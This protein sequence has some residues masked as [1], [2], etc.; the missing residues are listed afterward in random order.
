MQSAIWLLVVTFLF[1]HGDLDD[2]IR[3]VTQQINLTPD[4]IELY[5]MRGELYVAH[6]EYANAISD[7][8]HCLRHHVTNS[9]I[10]LGLS[11]SYLHSNQSD[12]ALVIIDKVLTLEPYNPNAKDIQASALEKLD[13][14]CEAA[15]VRESLVTIFPNA[16]P[17]IYLQ[18]ASAW[19]ACPDPAS[20]NHALEILQQGIHRTGYIRLL[21]QKL[22]SIYA[23]Q[24]KW[25]DAIKA[26]DE[27]IQQSSMKARPL[28]E[29]ATL[30]IRAGQVEKAKDDLLTALE[31]LDQL[32]MNKQE[33][34]SLKILRAD[35]QSLLSTIEN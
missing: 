7:F 29:R 24:E 9:R 26:Q 8:R 18:A 25:T 15:A 16:T 22:V 28:Y 2:R 12:S 21:Q 35:I 11:Q 20:T 33:I 34:V 10:Y 14:F 27:I 23:Q 6:E 1:P 32:P 5:Q 31:A 30:H 13:L 17:S 3:A 4:Q 19:L